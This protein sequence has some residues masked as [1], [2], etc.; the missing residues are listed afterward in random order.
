MKSIPLP[1]DVEDPAIAAVLRPSVRDVD[2]SS[3]GTRRGE[4]A[5]DSPAWR[6]GAD[7]QS[8]SAF[9]APL[10]VAWSR[11]WECEDGP[12][13]RRGMNFG[14]F[15]GGTPAQAVNFFSE[16]RFPVTRNKIYFRRNFEIPFL[17]SGPRYS[18]QIFSLTGLG[19]PRI[20]NAKIWPRPLRIWRKW[21]SKFFGVEQFHF[22]GSNIVGVVSKLVRAFS[23]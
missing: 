9:R 3:L 16:Q 4:R 11:L 8:R 17:G 19:R 12:E 2:R 23:I 13:R 7:R 15:I 18:Y 10:H 22:H 14:P 5:G 20:M 1:R 21:G 6:P